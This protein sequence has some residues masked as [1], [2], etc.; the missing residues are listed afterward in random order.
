MAQSARERCGL[1]RV[2]LIPAGF[3]P[4]KQLAVGAQTSDRLAMLRLAAETGAGLFVDP[5]ELT[6]EGPS[7]TVDTLHALHAQYPGAAFFLLLGGDML[8]SLPTWRAPREIAGLATLLAFP[9]GS[10]QQTSVCAQLRASFG[11]RVQ[12]LPPLPAAYAGI[13]SGMI[14]DR[15][16]NAL[17]ITGLVPPGVEDYLYQHL[18]YQPVAILSLAAKLRQGLSAARFAHSVR[19][20]QE[21]IRLAQLYRL[22]GMQ[23][24]LAG[25]LHDCAKELPR[26]DLEA[27]TGD[28]PSFCPTL[29]APA[30]AQ[31]AAREYGVT[32]PAVLPAIARHTTADSGMQPLD[33][34]L[35]IADRTE[36][37]RKNVRVWD[38]IRAQSDLDRAFSLAL[39]RSAW[40]TE[41]AGERLHPATIRAKKSYS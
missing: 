41:Q 27:L 12:E 32:D 23:A 3:P 34:L 11:A 19:V 21:A 18:L 39:T 33:K 4:H 2:L 36:L 22:N 14:R 1:D 6:R 16:Q 38:D 9:R 31:L 10:G 17:P 28:R 26:A 5:L 29:H 15:L 20:M 13:S 8:H 30:G 37:G 35:Y 25:L 7:Y 40:Y 24:R